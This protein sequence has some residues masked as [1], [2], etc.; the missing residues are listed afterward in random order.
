MKLKTLLFTLSTLVLLVVCVFLGY[1]LLSPGKILKA[2]NTLPQKAPQSPTVLFALRGLA[3][4]SSHISLEELGQRYC[5]GKVYVLASVKPLADS[6]FQCQ[7][8]RI[9]SHLKDFYQLAKTEIL[10]SDIEHLHNR[11]TTLA[12]DSIDYFS[13]PT[14]YPLKV[15]G[16]EGAFDYQKNI[17]KF[18]HTGVTAITR[19]TGLM[20]DQKGTDYIIEGV[21]SYFQDA[22]FVHISNEVSFYP[23]CNYDYS[24]PGV[25]RFCSKERDFQA[26]IDLNVNIVELTGN[27]NLD[28]G[29]EG[30]EQTFEWYQKHQMKTFGGGLSMEEANR[31]LLIDLKDGFQMA[32]VGFS[33]SCPVAECGRPNR[34]QGANAYQR[35]KARKTLATLK[36]NPKVKYI[37]ASVQ[38]NEVDSYSPTATQNQ[39][40][41]DLID[42]GADCVYGSQAHQVQKIEF[43]KDKP[44]FHGLGN[45]LFDQIHRIGVKQG[46]FLAH[47]LYK[48]RVVQSRIIYTMI[49][50][51]RRPEIASPE[52]AQVIKNIV[53][54]DALM[55]K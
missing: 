9:L 23:D 46:Y 32:F 6:I 27:H 7:N 10:I 19:N 35:E 52:E 42:F 11:Y 1:H 21:K 8:G 49:S 40:S 15:N 2:A 13:N 29:T 17:T 18:M 33:E 5:Q 3:T 31:P 4:D 53:F 25:Y 43:Y 28:F 51:G 26:F 38:F 14:K 22:D 24:Q 44:I 34:P 36:Q 55:Y 47:Y 30:Y 41:R 48:G 37:F 16:A 50:A 54:D 20:A 39:I 12:I 45:F